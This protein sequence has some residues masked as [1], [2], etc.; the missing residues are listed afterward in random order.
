MLCFS[1]HV[2]FVRLEVF[3]FSKFWMIWSG[4]FLPAVVDMII[5]KETFLSQFFTQDRMK[6]HRLSVALGV[7]FETSGC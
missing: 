6:R 4:F 1:I 7:M 5:L 2:N 3:F